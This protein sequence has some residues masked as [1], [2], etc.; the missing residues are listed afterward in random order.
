MTLWHCMYL[1]PTDTLPSLSPEM[2]Y[3][4]KQQTSKRSRDVDSVWFPFMFYARCRCFVQ[5]NAICKYSYITDHLYVLLLACLVYPWYVIFRGE[6]DTVSNM[7]RMVTPTMKVMFH[8][9]MGTTYNIYHWEVIF[10]RKTDKCLCMVDHST[11]VLWGSA[12]TGRH[13]PHPDH[14][15]ASMRVDLFAIYWMKGLTRQ[16]RSRYHC[17]KC[18]SVLSSVILQK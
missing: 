2:V 10:H 14:P 3:N 13:S 1:V 17:D 12:Q 15:I 5:N 8:E 7:V 6:I 18:P 4:Y 11:L 9:T 16:P